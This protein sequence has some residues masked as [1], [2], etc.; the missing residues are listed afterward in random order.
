MASFA[1]SPPGKRHAAQGP[2][3]SAGRLPGKGSPPGSASIAPP[4][5]ML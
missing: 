3:K 4:Q 2:L 1:C 5:I